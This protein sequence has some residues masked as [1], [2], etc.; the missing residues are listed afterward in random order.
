M[1]MVQPTIINIKES[2]WEMSPEISWYCEID[3]DSTIRIVFQKVPD[4]F[5]FL[6]IENAGSQL[7]ISQVELLKIF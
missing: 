7:T 4:N 6:P 5:P 1:A 2:D 3:S